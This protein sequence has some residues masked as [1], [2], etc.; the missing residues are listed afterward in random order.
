MQFTALLWLQAY[1]GFGIIL[2]TCAFGFIVVKNSVECMIARQYLC[3]ASAFMISTSLL[4]FT[5]LDDYSGYL[6]F[7][8]IYGFFY[9]GYNYSLRMFTY[10]KV[11]ARNYN[12]AWGFV[13]F[14]QSFPILVG[15]PI[16]GKFIMNFKAI[17]KAITT[18][19][20]FYSRLSERALWG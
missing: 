16:T 13:Q 11:R 12:R 18:T 19:L 7:V 2:G 20:D 1:L 14:V 10:E 15:V 6:L 3:Q 9:G 8:W 5:A 17:L 4:A